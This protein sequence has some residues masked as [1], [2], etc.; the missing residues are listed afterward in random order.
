MKRERVLHQTSDWW[1]QYGSVL[2]SYCVYIVHGYV[3]QTYNVWS[4]GAFGFAIRNSHSRIAFFALT[5][6]HAFACLLGAVS[7]CVY[8]FSVIENVTFCLLTSAR[9]SAFIFSH[10]DLHALFCRTACQ[11]DYFIC[12]RI[13]CTGAWF[14]SHSIVRIGLFVWALLL[15][16]FLHRSIYFRNKNRFGVTFISFI[17]ADCIVLDYVL[18]E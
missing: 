3:Y 6:L 16:I 2:Y 5:L 11:F 10:L 1:L 9:F 7:V 14:Y 12:F 4:S 17:S 18:R 8:Y 13:I 15:M